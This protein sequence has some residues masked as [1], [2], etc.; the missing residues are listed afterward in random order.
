M[1]A[2]K[3]AHALRQMNIILETDSNGM[4]KPTMG[5]TGRKVSTKKAM[6]A[7]LGYA[8]GSFLP[9]FYEF[10]NAETRERVFRRLDHDNPLDIREHSYENVM[11]LLRHHV[12]GAEFECVFTL[13]LKGQLRSLN[14]SLAEP[15][16]M[17][18]A[19]AEFA[20]LSVVCKVT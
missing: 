7:N 15:L 8:I 18:P 2:Q 17:L 5:I 12:F 9:W 13:C 11:D 19:L 1:S 20:T 4:L 16:T 3:P 6:N 14:E 10:V